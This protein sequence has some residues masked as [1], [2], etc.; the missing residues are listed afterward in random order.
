MKRIISLLLSATLCIVLMTACKSTQQVATS[1]S[2]PEWLQ[3]K[4][5]VLNERHSEITLFELDGQPYY[6]VFVKGP[7]KSFDMNRTTI[8][9][10]NGEVYLS[11][12]GPRK[13][14][15]KEIQFFNRAEN[16]GVIWQSDIAR[17]KKTKQ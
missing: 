8:Y 2:Y 1:S 6:A 9:D 11:L 15:D 5:D 10:A 7:D 12:G 14:N 3:A 17:E 13:R 4:M 16:K